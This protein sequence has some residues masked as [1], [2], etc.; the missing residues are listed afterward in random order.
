MRV[1]RD[2]IAVDIIKGELSLE[3]DSPLVEA[4]C[5]L[6]GWQMT[7]HGRKN[8]VRCLWHRH[9]I[10]DM[11]RWYIGLKTAANNMSRDKG[12]RVQWLNP[13]LAYLLTD[14]STSLWSMEKANMKRRHPESRRHLAADYYEAALIDVSVNTNHSRLRYIVWPVTVLLSS[15]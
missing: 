4:F 7:G 1:D 6:A 3:W 2:A 10:C 8:D 14:L 13:T 11:Q 15:F 12:E 9:L 5:Q